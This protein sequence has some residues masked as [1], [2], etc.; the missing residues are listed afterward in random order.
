MCAVLV[1]LNLTNKCVSDQ[2]ALLPKLHEM[3][4]I[5]LPVLLAETS[6]SNYISL[7][8]STVCCQ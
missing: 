5:K 6:I 8:L 4:N 3:L 1:R 2:Q 7:L